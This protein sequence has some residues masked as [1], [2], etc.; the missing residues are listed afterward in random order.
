MRCP[1][2]RHTA[3]NACLGERL[4]RL[5][6]RADYAGYLAAAPDPATA[7]AVAAVAARN[8]LLARV[9]ACPD[10]GSVLPVSLQAECGCGELSEC[11]AGRGSVSGR[12]TLQ[13]CMDC[14]A[15]TVGAVV[16]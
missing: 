5:C 13:N 14:R 11:R 1:D 10:R 16:A 15:S 8:G 9:A 12:V 3:E 2:C 6:G 4:P 7:D